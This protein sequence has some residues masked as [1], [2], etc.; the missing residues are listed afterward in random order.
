MKIKK[1]WFSKTIELSESDFDKFF[2]KNP[3][4]ISPSFYKYN[5]TLFIEFLVKINFLKIKKN[6][7]RENIKR[8]DSI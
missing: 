5:R 3:Y 1:T 4:D 6:V 8:T 7:R 2:A